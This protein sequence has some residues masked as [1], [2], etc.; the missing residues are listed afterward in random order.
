MCDRVIASMPSGQYDGM[1]AQAETCMA[2]ADCATFSTC[3]KDMHRAMIGA[4]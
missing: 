2:A 3:T 1:R 4:Q